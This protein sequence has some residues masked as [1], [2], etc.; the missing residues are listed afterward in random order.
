M[1]DSLSAAYNIS[2][3]QSWPQL[4]QQ[5]LVAALNQSQV[6]NASISGETS[7]G[8]L[9]R[10]ESLLNQHRPTHLI[11]E[12]GGNDGLR[13][14]KFRQ[15]QDNLEAMIRKALSRDIRVLLIGVRLPPNLG[16]VYNQRFQLIFSQLAEQHPIEYLPRF[17]E[18]IAADRPEYMQADGIHPTA[19]AQPLLA[20]RVFTAFQSSYLK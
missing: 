2:I 13:G 8:G 19:V 1:G 3:E 16:M 14:Y 7:N 12:L 10:L 17:L 6:V 11:L 20:D 4:F 9:E 5:K 18:G 15:T